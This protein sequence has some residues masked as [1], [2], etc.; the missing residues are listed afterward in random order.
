[1]EKEMSGDKVSEDVVARDDVWGNEVSERDAS[2]SRTTVSGG[3][4]AG[5]EVIRVGVLAR[6]QVA[7]GEVEVVLVDAS[8]LVGVEAEEDDLVAPILLLGE[9]VLL[10]SL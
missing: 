9:H 7:W 5:V 6:T 4:V 2:P 3:L 8:V 1:M 10:E